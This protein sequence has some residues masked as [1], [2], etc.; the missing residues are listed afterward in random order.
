VS[1][2]LGAL[3]RFEEIVPPEQTTDCVTELLRGREPFDGLA[4]AVFGIAGKE[5]T[6]GR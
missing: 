5:R 4:G 3:H 2:H 6:K 1:V